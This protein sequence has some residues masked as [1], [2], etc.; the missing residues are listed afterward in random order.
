MN[1]FE[2]QRNANAFNARETGREVI[3]S[4]ESQALIIELQKDQL[5]QGE[6]MLGEPIEPE[7]RSF[8]YA[9]FKNRINPRAGFGTPDLR[10]SGA[11]YNAFFFDEDD[12][13]VYSRDE[14]VERLIAKYGA[15]FGLNDDSVERYRQYFRR[16]YLERRIAQLRG[17]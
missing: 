8:S 3:L 14:K 16:K 17:R 6:N 13:E 2:L 1:I 11:F 7:Y 10:Y 12:M 4:S 15:I 5:M 9:R